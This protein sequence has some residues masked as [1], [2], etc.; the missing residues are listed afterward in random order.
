MLTNKKVSD[1]FDLLILS[2]EDLWNKRSSKKEPFS[3]V[4]II[5]SNSKTEKVPNDLIDIML[6]SNEAKEEFSFIMKDY[7]KDQNPQGIVFCIEAWVAKDI[8]EDLLP[9]SYHNA[10]D[11]A[12]A[13]AECVHDAGGAKAFGSLYGRTIEVLFLTAEDDEGGASCVTFEIQKDGSLL[14]NTEF[15]DKYTKA[16]GRFCNFFNPE[17]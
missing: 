6:S 14:R 17:N 13:M 10:K 16:S 2:I 3:H 1:Y 9:R 4:W 11:K 12:A 15:E 7:V 8:N 5:R